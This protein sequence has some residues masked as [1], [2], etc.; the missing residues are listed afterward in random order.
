MC[1]IT[2]I[3]YLE[4]NISA[5]KAIFEFNQAI[6]HRGPDGEGYYSDENQNFALGHRRLAILDLSDLGKQPMSALDGRFQITYNGEVFNFLEIRKELENLGWKFQ[7]DSDTEVILKAYIEWGKRAFFKF[8]GMWAFG[9]WDTQEGELLLCRDRFGIKPLFFVDSDNLFAFASE[10]SAFKHLQGFK[11]EANSE[12]FQAQLQNFGAL[13]SIGLTLFK[14]IYQLPAGHFLV[15]KANSPSKST[16]WWN[17]KEN[18]PTPPK[19]FGEQ[20][21][22]FRNLFE[23]SCRLRLR[24]DVPIATALSGGLDSSS[25]YSMLQ[26]GKANRA[27]WERTP[28]NWQRAF[29]AI[30]PGTTMDELEFAKQVVNKYQGELSTIDALES[31]NLEGDILKSIQLF[32]NFY[33]TPINVIAQIYQSMR[34][35]GFVVSMDGHGVDE[36]LFGYNSDVLELYKTS[37]R[38]GDLVYAK[39]V[40]KC[41]IH[42]FPEA[43]R[44]LAESHLKGILAGN[45]TIQSFKKTIKGLFSK[46]PIQMKAHDDSL[47]CDDLWL[48]GYNSSTKIS[49]PYLQVEKLESDPYSELM[50]RQFHSGILPV[51]L[52]NFDR[53]SMQHGVEIRMPFMD[54][55]LV[56]FMMSLP[57]KA[58]LGE[59]FNKRIIR[60]GMK[61]ILPEPIRNRTFKMS[62]QAPMHIWLGGHLKSFS[63]DAIRSNSFL[64]SD[65]WDGKRIADEV[66]QKFRLNTWDFQS[67]SKL[68]HYLNAYFLLNNA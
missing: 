2:G 37:M 3:W 52:R 6:S 46:L 9:I 67:S 48:G 60:E 21:G 58:K 27:D 7:S 15:K 5:K 57:L 47:Y 32:D 53:A 19:N 63:M 61:G 28:S 64:N 56:T 17:T 26:F 65:I 14:R 31:S 35:E 38:L 18:L 42:L 49:S 43:E 68:W 55:R 59:G 66:E 8:N 30:F 34:S 41:Y 13:E 10:T 44:K 36:M 23:D 54:Y 1:G 62:I 33:I 50:Y 39:E 16:R 29:C 24:S 4:N 12:H 25:V 51:I 45:K 20:A 11:R 40:A 22:L